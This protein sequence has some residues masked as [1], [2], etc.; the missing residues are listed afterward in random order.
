M[1]TRQRRRVATVLGSIIAAAAMVFA[2]MQVANAQ[3]PRTADP[4]NLPPLITYYGAI[5]MGE[6]G[7]KGTSRRHLSKL[8][9]QQAAM[10]RCGHDT[11]KIVSTFTRCGAVAHQGTTYHGGIGLNRGMAEQHAMSQLG[12]GQIVHWACN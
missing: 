4:P 7:S 6:D 8:G 9:A 2:P 5:A 12:G 3:T 10:E 1:T 11:C